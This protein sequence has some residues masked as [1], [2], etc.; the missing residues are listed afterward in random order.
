VSLDEPALDAWIDIISPTEEDI[1]SLE[2]MVEIDEDILRSIHDYDEVPKM[3]KYDGYDFILLQ[4]PKV[5][6]DQEEDEETNDD[7]EI[8]YKY[9]VA[10][11]GIIFKPDLII[12]LSEGKNDIVQYLRIKLKN[13]QKN[14]IVNTFNIPQFV[15]KLLLFTSKIYLRYLKA[16]N[17]KLRQVQ[18]NLELSAK[19][20]EIMHLMDL[21]KSIVYFN[22]SLQSN[23]VVIEKIAKKKFF[24]GSEDNEELIEDILDENK[25]AI[26]TVKIYGQI[27]SSTSNTFTSVISNNLNA[28]LRFLTTLTIILMIPT[29]VAS[30]YGM[31]V[32][33]PFQNSQHAFTIVVAISLVL[34][35]LGAFW[36][37]RKKLF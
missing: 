35:M 23:Q 28:T 7:D 11:L 31:N 37:Y 6:I 18:R 10:P 19:N 8:Y 36:F 29:L 24:T 9:S 13:F 3:E 26:S 14:R 25:Q 2:Q 21:Q 15:L 12:T 1:K 22:T 27:I 4:T 32:D 34:S 30:V 16:I 20:D 17:Q 33:L 5:T